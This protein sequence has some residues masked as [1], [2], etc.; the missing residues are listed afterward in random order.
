M[1]TAIMVIGLKNI[2]FMR[3]LSVLVPT[4]MAAIAW[5]SLLA[6]KPF[7]LQ[8]A[9]ESVP[10]EQWNDAG[11]IA[12][13]RH[14]TIVWGFLFLVSVAV[15]LCQFLHAGGPE[16]LYQTISIGS[17]LGGM[18]YTQWFKNRIKRQRARN[19]RGQAGGN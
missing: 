14:L 17:V 4:S 6:G 5:L 9:R 18:A 12:N 7:V 10:M 16:W 1:V 19:D 11:F 13:C 8:I 15:S 2:W 3:H